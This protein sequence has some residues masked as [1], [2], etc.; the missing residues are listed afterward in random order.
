MDKFTAQQ[1]SIMLDSLVDKIIE[2]RQKK[3]CLPIDEYREK[4]NSTCEIIVKITSGFSQSVKINE[5]QEGDIK[6]KDKDFE[7]VSSDDEVVFIKTNDCSKIHVWEEKAK[8][9]LDW[10]TENKWLKELIGILGGSATIGSCRQNDNQL[11][12]NLAM[13]MA[14][15]YNKKIN[16]LDKNMHKNLSDFFWRDEPVRHLL[17][18]DREVVYKIDIFKFLYPGVKLCDTTLTRYWKCRRPINK[19]HK[20]TKKLYCGY[21]HERPKK[22]K[23]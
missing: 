3:S 4:L 6:G 19:I 11:D 20:I 10:Q 2:I 22:V 13:E 8:I 16:N 17:L 12:T 21:D 1:E 15:L 14:N 5:K 18:R 7:A 9:S 23:K